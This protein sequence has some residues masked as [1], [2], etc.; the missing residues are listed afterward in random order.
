MS[1]RSPIVGVNTL[2]SPI[3]GVNTLRSP[4]VGVNTLKKINN[5]YSQ[6][7]KDLLYLWSN[8]VITS[9]KY[10]SEERI[11]FNVKLLKIINEV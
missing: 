3:V 11:H 8:G 6:T 7:V 1:L 5:D 4:I 9:K 10:H 2:R